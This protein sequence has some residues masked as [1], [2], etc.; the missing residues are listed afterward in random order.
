MAA[1]KDQKL[2]DFLALIDAIRIGKTRE[3]TIAARKI[4]TMIREMAGNDKS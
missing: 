3:R 4:E 1:L 2:H